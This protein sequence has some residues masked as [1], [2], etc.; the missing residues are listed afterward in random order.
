MK[1]VSMK[2]FHICLILLSL[3]CFIAVSA[4]AEDA[5]PFASEYYSEATVS[6]S[7]SKVIS[8]ECITYA[9]CNTIKVSS[10]SLQKLEGSSWVSVSGYSKPSKTASGRTYKAMLDC[11]SLIG[12]GT[13]R[14]TVTYNADGHLKS[15]SA[16]RTF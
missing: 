14:V 5:L 16:T 12:S 9:S 15:C 6:I 13:Y 1:N 2:S 10:S 8:F 3:F 11:S 4:A 7:S